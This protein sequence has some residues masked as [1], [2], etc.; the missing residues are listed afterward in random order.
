MAKG[1]NRLPVFAGV[2]LLA[3]L[4]AACSS[5]VPGTSGPIDID[6]PQ[7]SATP[8]FTPAEIPEATPSTWSLQAPQ[9]VITSPSKP[10]SSRRTPFISQGFS[11]E[12]TPAI[13]L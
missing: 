4:L 13:L 5:N 7:A 1:F 11:L 8:G 10:H 3:V 9:S 2:L 6:L 12:Y